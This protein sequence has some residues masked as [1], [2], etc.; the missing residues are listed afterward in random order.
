MGMNKLQARYLAESLMSQH[1][2]DEWTFAFN[3]RKSALGVCNYT[4][5]TI[6]LSEYFIARLSDDK[7][8]DTILH[9]IA[10]AI[11]GVAAKHGPQWKAVCVRIGADP[12]RCYTGEIDNP[13]Y[14]Y[15]IKCKS[16]NS[17]HGRHR[18]NKGKIKQFQ[19]G[20]S[21]F[22]CRSC[23]TRMDI[24]DG[25]KKI[26]DAEAAKRPAQPTAKEVKAMTDKELIDYLIKNGK[27]SA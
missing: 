7:I 4:K 8:K 16:C 17:E 12:T 20:F 21:W 2:S 10:H 19:T 18:F 23:G 13:E 25:T 27:I 22:N 15:K 9:E 5:K 1:L 6:Y 14:R 11:A 24:F 26:V 3:K